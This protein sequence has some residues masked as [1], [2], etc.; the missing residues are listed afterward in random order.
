MKETSDTFQ[1]RTVDIEIL[2]QNYTNPNERLMGTIKL[3]PKKYHQ[4][5]T[6][7]LN[8]ISPFIKLDSMGRVMYPDNRSGSNLVDLVLFLVSPETIRRPR[9][10]DIPKFLEICRKAGCPTNAL[11]AGRSF[12]DYPT[13]HEDDFEDEE[14]EE[15]TPVEEEDV[16]LAPTIPK[17]KSLY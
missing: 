12:E 2:E 8:A 10:L 4:K 13:H 15:F 11:G 1:P 17:W 6:L 16:L 9:P 5:A 3:L 14:D 7:M